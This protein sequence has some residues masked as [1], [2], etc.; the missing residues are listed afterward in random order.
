MTF[1]CVTD[2]KNENLNRYGHIAHRFL[3]YIIIYGGGEEFFSSTK[4]IRPLKSNLVIYK[5]QKNKYHIVN[6]R[7]PIKKVRAEASFI[8]GKYLYYY[9]GST[10]V[11][12]VVDDLIRIKLT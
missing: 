2:V 5:P 8:I 1:D 4:F 7:V 9:G 11:G 12:E 10:Q 6:F 3:N